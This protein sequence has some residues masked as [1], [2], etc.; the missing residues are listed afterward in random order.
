FAPFLGEDILE[1]KKKYIDKYSKGNKQKIGIVSAMLTSSKLLILDEPFNYLD[2]SSQI[3]MKKLLQDYNQKYNTTVLLSSH[4]LRYVMDICSR[5]IVLQSGHIVQDVSNLDEEAKA[6]I[7][8][9]FEIQKEK[10][11]EN[12]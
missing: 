11:T 6:D 1:S 5:I 2:P 4:N 3:Q 9:Y 10:F 7:E 8:N 12:Q